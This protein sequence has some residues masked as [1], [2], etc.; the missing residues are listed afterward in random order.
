YDKHGEPISYDFW[1][2]LSQIVE[3]IC[4]HWKK[5]DDGIWEVRGGAKQFLYSRA[6]CWLAIDRAMQIARR[7][8]YPAPLVRWLKVR[9]KIYQNIYEEFWNPKLNSFVQYRGA[10]SVDAAA[11]LL[12]LV[13]FMSPT[14]PRWKSTLKAIEKNL[15]EDSLVY[16]Y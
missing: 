12:P 13:H 1:T 11:L 5:P 9:N 3:W 10:K 7:R 8:A 2:N 4:G 16:R 15:V 14:D 6:M